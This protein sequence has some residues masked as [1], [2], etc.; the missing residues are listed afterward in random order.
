MKRRVSVWALLSWEG[1]PNAQL[2]ALTSCQDFAK[3]HSQRALGDLRSSVLRH[4]ATGSVGLCSPVNFGNGGQLFQL[5]LYQR[6]IGLRSRRCIGR[7][8]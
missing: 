8:R 5:A 6:I 4:Q 1:Y 2:S 3:V 7:H